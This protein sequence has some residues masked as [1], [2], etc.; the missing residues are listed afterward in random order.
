MANIDKLNY[1]FVD[2]QT[3][4]HDYHLN[5]M[6]GRI[7]QLIDAVGGSTPTQQ[8]ATPTISISGT[9][10]TI[11]CSTSGA[12]IYYTTN[13]NTP[14]TSSTQ[15]SSPITLSAACTIKAI[16]VKSGMNN[17]SVASQTY[18]PSSQY[19]YYAASLSAGKYK[20]K[21]EDVTGN[22]VLVNSSN[23]VVVTLQGASGYVEITSAQATQI[24][25]VGLESGQLTLTPM[26]DTVYEATSQSAYTRI[27]NV[28]LD[29]GTYHFKLVDAGG[30]ANFKDTNE[31][32][33]LSIS[34]GGDS[35]R[36]VSQEMSDRIT[37]LSM[38]K[39]VLT[40]STY[41]TPQVYGN[42]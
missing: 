15:Y 41:G 28:H 34:V 12:T 38:F 22:A 10:A 20:Y 30:V 32:I 1:S 3:T 8:V 40:V 33:V 14:T 26:T 39:G 27:D 31:Q 35:D 21:A 18:T 24:A 5:E 4:I 17:S 19:Q 16:A 23:S 25:K 13:G 9:T 11:T 2:G 29:A 6:V 7:N 36:T 37:Y 42:S